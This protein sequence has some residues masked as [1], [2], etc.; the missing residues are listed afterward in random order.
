M[1]SNFNVDYVELA[2]AF[3]NLLK[4]M[5]NYIK[6]KSLIDTLHLTKNLLP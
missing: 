6:N 3:S 5:K 2:L 1:E 4:L